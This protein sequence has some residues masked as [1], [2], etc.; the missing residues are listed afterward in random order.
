MWITYSA[1]AAAADRP[2]TTRATNRERPGCESPAAEC[3]GFRRS[4]MAADG[5]V[6]DGCRDRGIC[7]LSH[8]FDIPIGR[9]RWRFRYGPPLRGLSQFGRRRASRRNRTRGFT[10]VGKTTYRRVDRQGRT[11]LS[12]IRLREYSRASTNGDVR[13]RASERCESQGRRPRA[14]QG[15]GCHEP[16]DSDR[17]DLRRHRRDSRRLR[18][19]RARDA[20]R[21]RPARELADGRAVPPRSIPPCW[22][23]WRFSRRMAGGR[24]SSRRGSS[25]WGSPSFRVR[26][27]SWC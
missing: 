24:F 27:I 11:G 19:T 4:E 17:V 26:S 13:R 1:L 12:S 25:V 10:R 22:R 2:N 7:D 15:E 3:R 16:M 18:S 21:G 9:S 23:R 20:A 6:R 8:G 14:F 5:A